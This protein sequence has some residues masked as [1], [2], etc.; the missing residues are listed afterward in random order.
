M[1]NFFKSLNLRE[2]ICYAISAL[3]VVLMLVFLFPAWYVTNDGMPLSV[4]SLTA[5]GLAFQDVLLWIAILGAIV[6]SVTSLCVSLSLKAKHS[7]KL[8]MAC[9]KLALANL[10]YPVAFAVV[11]LIYGSKIP[12]AT[13][14]PICFA[15]FM[16][17]GGI[18]VFVANRKNS[19]Q[20]EEAQT[21]EE[22]NDAYIKEKRDRLVAWSKSKSFDAY[23]LYKQLEFSDYDAIGFLANGEKAQSSSQ[24]KF[25]DSL[26]GITL[27]DFCK[28][29]EKALPYIGKL[30]S[31]RISTGKDKA[32]FNPTTNC[33]KGCKINVT[34]LI[35]STAHTGVGANESA[36]MSAYDDARDEAAYSGY[37]VD[38]NDFVA[39]NSEAYAAAVDADKANT[40]NKVSESNDRKKKIARSII[41]G[42][43]DKFNIYVTSY[44]HFAKIKISDTK[45]KV[46]KVKG[47]FGY[48]VKDIVIH[49]EV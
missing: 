7:Y 23:E 3:C 19:K 48:P 21:R 5:V 32:E 1:K 43:S 8:S 25:N 49:Y 14:M 30:P 40:Y 6:I 9:P 13:A 39:V 44:T 24:G 26:P 28:V 16:L 22:A 2:L 41:F 18:A 38:W 34:G 42:L 31:S 10:I 35:Q 45:Y 17:I 47:F 33:Y 27:S 4:F 20:K 12:N 11:L 15:V 29:C 46:K 36:F 37:E